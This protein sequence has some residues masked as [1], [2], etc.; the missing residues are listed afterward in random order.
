MFVMDLGL[1][2][3]SVFLLRVL[4]GAS[5]VET[6]DIPP[7]LYSAVLSCKRWCCRRRQ[8]WNRRLSC[9]RKDIIRVKSS[10]FSPCNALNKVTALD[11]TFRCITCIVELDCTV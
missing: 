9:S 3:D 2:K 1:W 8:C 7:R 11:I 4:R 10:L 5:T 6:R